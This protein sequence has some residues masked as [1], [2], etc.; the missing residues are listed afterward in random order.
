MASLSATGNPPRSPVSP[1][2]GRGVEGRRDRV[3]P[4][5]AASRTVGPVRRPGPEAELMW[6]QRRP[7][8]RSDPV[9]ISLHERESHRAD[10]TYGGVSSTGYSNPQPRDPQPRGKKRLRA[11]LRARHV[12]LSIPSSAV[13]TGGLRRGFW[14]RRRGLRE[15]G[16]SL[17]SREGGVRR[18]ERP[19]GS[20]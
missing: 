5:D 2:L 17:A 18:G 3:L 16:G 4:V 1:R 10:G 13:P 6:K 19:G 8:V 7:S 20:G 15:R 14:R 12:T 9:W 11:S